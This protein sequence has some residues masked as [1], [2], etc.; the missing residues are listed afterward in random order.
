MRYNHDV[1]LVRLFTSPANPMEGDSLALHAIVT[2][3][4]LQA[5][6]GLSMEVFLDADRDSLPRPEERVAMIVANTFIPSGD[7]TDIGVQLGA[8]PAGRH[9]LIA[10]L[11]YELD[12][13]TVNNQ[14]CTSVSVG[15]APHTLI[16]NEIMFAPFAAAAEY[17]ELVNIGDNDVDLSGWTLA[18]RKAGSQ[19]ANGITI[20]EEGQ[21][22][23]PWEYVVLGSD[24]SLLTWFPHLRQIDSRL[25]RICTADWLALNNEGDDIIVRD[26][27]G[28][29]IDSVAYS[30]LWHNPGVEDQTG[31]SLEKIRPA[32]R[33]NDARNWS[34]CAL[35]VGGT[36]GT[37]NSI[38]APA[39]GLPDA[40]LSILPNPFSP[41]GDGT[42]DFAV[43]SYHLVSDVSMLNV[44]IYD[45]RGR[46][47]RCLVNNEPAGARGEIV[48]DGRDDGGRKARIG[49][50]VVLL[51]ALNDPGGIISIAKGLVVLAARL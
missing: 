23:R 47:V 30:P 44:K 3:V 34:T 1:K 38:Y 46:L 41:D 50:Y 21:R 39:T 18:D 49:P 19:K 25:V 27:M 6:Q 10:R 36:P 24:S 45:I 13:D 51:E 22:I 20:G 8:P 37:V 12:R 5:V 15:Y 29:V 40:Q 17:V 2:N 42:E 33:S 28:H 32:G 11:L 35:S 7:S 16:V 31:R 14:R 48:W 43:I 9:A 4:G 26:P